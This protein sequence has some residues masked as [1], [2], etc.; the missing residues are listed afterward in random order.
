MRRSERLSSRIIVKTQRLFCVPP[1]HL[2]NRLANHGVGPDDAGAVILAQGDN[3]LRQHNGALTHRQHVHYLS[4]AVGCWAWTYSWPYYYGLLVQP[5]QRQNPY[6]QQFVLITGVV[7][8][9]GS[10]L[11]LRIDSNLFVFAYGFLIVVGEQKS[12]SLV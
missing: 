5:T 6:L 7:M 11:E 10:L 2:A 1:S 12:F 8:L 9:F 4:L 3:D